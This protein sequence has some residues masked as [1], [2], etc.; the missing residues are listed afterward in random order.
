[1]QFDSH[2]PL[3]K[4]CDAV[5]FTGFQP[6]K[7]PVKPTILDAVGREIFGTS[8]FW[9]RV[10]DGS[11]ELGSMVIHILKPDFGLSHFFHVFTQYLPSGRKGQHGSVFQKGKRTDEKWLSDKPAYL[12]FWR[13]IPGQLKAKR[14][15]VPLG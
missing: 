15:V 1:M 8:E 3:Q 13:D 5:G 4:P 10:S 14:E 6:R 12:R 9:T 2:R 11:Q 7:F